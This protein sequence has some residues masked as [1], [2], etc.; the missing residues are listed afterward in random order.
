MPGEAALLEIVRGRD[1]TKDP[2]RICIHCLRS[3]VTRENRNRHSEKCVN[4]IINPNAG[5]VQKY[6]ACIKCG[7]LYVSQG[8]LLNTWNHVVV[9]CTTQPRLTY[10]NPKA[11][12]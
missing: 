8:N 4:G 12:K 3:F 1:V 10:R 9:L 7:K 6:Y 2:E 11:E 5:V